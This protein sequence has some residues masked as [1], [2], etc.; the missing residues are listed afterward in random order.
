MI[1][2]SKPS[3]IRCH[4]TVR[5]EVSSF[6]YHGIFPSTCDALL[7]AL[8]MYGSAHVSVRAMK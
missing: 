1:N 2:S 3:S 4:V 6:S 5:T 8:D 7:A